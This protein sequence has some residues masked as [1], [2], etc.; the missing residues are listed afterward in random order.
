MGARVT[1]RAVPAVST[2]ALRRHR[3]GRREPHCDRTRARARASPVAFARGSTRVRSSLDLQAI[4]RGPL[5]GRAPA[6][7][8]E[9]GSTRSKN[10]V[11]GRAGEDGVVLRMLPAAMGRQPWEITH[12]RD[13]LEI[14]KAAGLPVPEVL[15]ADPSGRALGEPALLV[16]QIRGRARLGPLSGAQL[17]A[18]AELCGRLRDARLSPRVHA[19][20]SDLDENLDRFLAGPRPPRFAGPLGREIWTTLRRS[21][22]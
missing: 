13:A 8:R 15:W 4:L 12:E 3:L 14:G 2:R 6:S 17:R 16:R 9:L 19:R 10:L 11:I 1:R 21:R 22:P 5:R 7:V 18:L 20:L